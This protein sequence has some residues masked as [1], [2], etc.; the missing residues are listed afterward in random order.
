MK[1]RKILKYSLLIAGFIIPHMSNAQETIANFNWLSEGVVTVSETGNETFA[2]LTDKND[3]TFYVVETSNSQSW[4]KYESKTPIVLTSYTLVSSYDAQRDPQKWKLE[5]SEDGQTWKT[6]HMKSN[7]IFAG[8]NHPLNTRTGLVGGIKGYRFYRLTIQ[9][10]ENTTLKFSLAELQFFGSY[11]TLSPNAATNVGNLTAQY[12]EDGGLTNLIDNGFSSYK[13]EQSLPFWI[14]YESLRPMKLGTYALVTGNDITKAPRAWELHGSN[15]GQTWDILD[16]QRNKNFFNAPHSTQVYK[17]NNTS[18]QLDWTKIAN[19][20]YSTLIT[21]YWGNYSQGGKY[22]LAGYDKPTSNPYGYNYWWQAH[23]LDIFVDR[24]KRS[25]D[26]DYQVKIN[27]LSQGVIGFCKTQ[28]LPDFYHGFYDDMEWLALAFLRNYEATKN[29]VYLNHT[30]KLWDWIEGGWSDVHGGGIAWSTGTPNGKNACSNAPAII[31][32][33][34]LYEATDDIKYLDF[35]KKIYDWMDP[36]L[37]DQSNGLVWDN[38]H[39][40]KDGSGNETNISETEKAVWS[41]NV[42]TWIGGC[43]ELYLKTGDVKYL[44]K[45]LISADYV[46]SDYQKFSKYGV[47]T[48]NEDGGAD[49]GLFKGIFVRYLAQLVLRGNLDK[50]RESR[51]VNY[52]T[53]TAEALWNA[54]VLKPEMVVAPNWFDKPSRATQSSSTLMSGVMLFES[55]VELEAKGFLKAERNVAKENSEKEYKYFRLNIQNN[56]RGEKLSGV[57]IAEWQLFDA[58]YS[59]IEENQSEPSRVNIYTENQSIIISPINIGGQYSYAVYDLTG[60]ILAQGVSHS[61]TLLPMHL[62][63]AYIVIVD[64]QDELVRK[65]IVL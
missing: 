17:I 62:K 19:A 1:G 44:D 53:G 37:V 27:D 54:G 18:K 14:Q 6:L 2:N 65:K 15:D 5:Y 41:Y 29:P 30:K 59:S 47:V 61:E 24:Y 26:V 56:V 9:S 40:K 55:L 4:I 16:V 32:A 50:E 31:L 48:N 25:K 63:G 13:Q 49:G 8:R 46:V 20:L 39:Y 12:G 33:V 52:L 11:E 38:V 22:F 43:L 57:E 7:Q 34:R 51:Y 10:P 64:L 36:I 21:D 45:A 58:T 35:A 60:K 3:T 42:G 23:G 28:N